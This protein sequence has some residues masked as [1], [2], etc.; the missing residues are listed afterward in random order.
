DIHDHIE[1]LYH[2]EVDD[3]LVGRVV[4]RVEPELVAWRSRAL[5]PAWACVFIDAVHLKVRHTT[6][7]ESTAV[8]IAGGYDCE[9]RRHMLGVWMAD[10]GQTGDSASFWHRALVELKGR[11]VEDIF[12]VCADGLAGLEEAV[13]ASFPAARFQPCVVHLIRNSTRY[14]PHKHR[15]EAITDI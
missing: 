12:I 7:A 10:E 13:G 11:G 1:S 5:T 3:G 15:K 6:G 4:A 8:Y 2:L 14:V 9:G